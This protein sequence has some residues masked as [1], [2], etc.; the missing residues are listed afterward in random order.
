MD[1]D[2]QEL[3][4]QIAQRDG[5]LACMERGV[6]DKRKI[7]EGVDCSRPTV[8][9]AIRELEN[10]GVVASTGSTYELTVFG[11]LVY[12][13]YLN[14]VSRLHDC[15][16]A[17]EL[18]SDPTIEDVVP[19]VY[20]DNANV[21]PVNEAG[22]NQSFQRF[23]RL[24]SESSRIEGV[25]SVIPSG[26][27]DLVTGIEDGTDQDIRIVFGEEAMNYLTDE[28][29]DVYERNCCSFKERPSLPTYSTFIFERDS[30]WVGVYGRQNRF[31]GSLVNSSSAAVSNAIEAWESHWESH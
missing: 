1:I 4:T 13:K 14:S 19:M 11:K 16:E 12:R 28:F 26:F 7:T 30:V 15:I 6:T 25:S 8:D 29:P 24:L 3:L 20:I 21:Y 9:R 18:L 23:S 5:I 27:P 31:F 2:T 17:H 22:A 10:Y